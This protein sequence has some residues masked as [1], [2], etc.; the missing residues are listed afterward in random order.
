[1][2]RSKKLAATAAHRRPKALEFGAL[3]RAIAGLV[4]LMVTGDLAAA[5]GDRKRH[6]GWE[7]VL[8]PHTWRGYTHATGDGTATWFLHGRDAHVLDGRGRWEKLTGVL[9]TAVDACSAV[10]RNRNGHIVVVPGRNKAG[11]VLDPETRKTTPVPALALDTRRGAL[12]VVDDAGRLFVAIGGRTNQWGWLD[13][14]RFRPLPKMTTVT[15]L[16]KFSSGLFAL[17]STML[18]FGDHHVSQ[19]DFPKKTWKADLFTVLGMRPAF[20][21]GGMTCHDRK[22]QLVFM[23]LGKRSR[24]LGVMVLRTVGQLAAQRFYFLKPRLPI[25]LEDIDRTLFV[26][27]SGAE[28][29]I[30]LLSRSHGAVYR[31]RYNDVKGVG[32]QNDIRADVGSDWEV[33]NSTRIGNIGDLCRERDSVCND[34][35]V[36]PYFYNQRKNIVQ[37]VRRYDMR[38]NSPSVGPTFGTRF[39]TEGSAI[40]HDGK[41]RIYLC[42]GYL[43]RFW[44]LEL[45]TDNATGQKQADLVA[46]KDLRATPLSDIPVH[47]YSGRGEINHDNGGGNTVLCHHAGSVFGMFDPVTRILWRYDIGK[48]RW[49]HATILPAGLTYTSRDGIDFFSD[50]GRL[51]VLTRSGV[52]SYTSA[53]GWSPVKRLDLPYSSNGGMAALDPATDIA[54]VVRGE[55]TRDLATVNVKT[56]EQ[57]ILKDHLPDVVSVPGRRISIAKWKDVK[58]VTIYRGHDTAERWRLKLPKDGRL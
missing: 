22:N 50:E 16:G 32:I 39:A 21:R 24:T 53:D 45:R 3:A 58:Y 46:I 47:D 42:N 14:G 11:F 54:Y 48:N 44:A 51:W 40:C 33:W 12:A 13:A 41:D 25:L 35:S 49:S 43:R 57:K 6:A 23:T 37:R 55:G 8:L 18:A 27:G 38:Q 9:P 4:V 34:V 26:T 1:M 5:Q 36:P 31:I 10:C 20:D 7:R 56:G 2:S 30:N 52:G 15:T 19:F 17:G 28:A 29:R